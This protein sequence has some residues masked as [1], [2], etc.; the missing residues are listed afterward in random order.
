MNTE[1]AATETLVY[2]V[3]ESVKYHTQFCSYTYKGS[4]LSC[5]RHAM[6][7][8]VATEKGLTACAHCLGGE[9]IVVAPSK[10]MT[11]V[12]SGFGKTFLNPKRVYGQCPDCGKTMKNT[13]RGLP[14]HKPEAK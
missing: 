1:S 14:K 10:P 7:V 5:T 3:A 8:A 12:C 13:G 2:A 11:E 4:P 9:A 6:T